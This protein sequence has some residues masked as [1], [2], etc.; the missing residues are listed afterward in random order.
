MVVDLQPSAVVDSG[1]LDTYL[2][3][4]LSRGYRVAADSLMS[5]EM[6]Q[7]EIGMQLSSVP[8]TLRSVHGYIGS[9][10]CTL[11]G[12]YIVNGHRLVFLDVRVSYP[13]TTSSGQP[14]SGN[15]CTLDGAQYEYQAPRWS[16]I[17]N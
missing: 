3:L 9:G 8:T 16:K 17:A 7:L 1:A 12:K 10:S 6:Q 11:T 4:D 14:A 13:D 15:R 5:F 2:P